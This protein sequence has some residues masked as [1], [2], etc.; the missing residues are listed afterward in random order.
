V[1]NNGWRSVPAL[2]TVRTLKAVSHFWAQNV[3]NGW[4][5]LF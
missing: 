4:S 1:N 5:F 3:L 2:D